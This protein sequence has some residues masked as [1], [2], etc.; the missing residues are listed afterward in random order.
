MAKLHQAGLVE[1]APEKPESYQ[2]ERPPIAA[3][4]GWD[5]ARETDFRSAAHAMGLTQ[6]QV[7]GLVNWQAEDLTRAVQAKQAEVETAT[8]VLL[9]EW[10]A[11]FD[12]KLGRAEQVVEAFFPKSKALLKKTGVNNMP[13]FIRELVAVGSRFA[14]HGDLPGTVEGQPS[15]QQIDAAIAANREQAAKSLNAAE[16]VRLADELHALYQQKLGDTN[17]VHTK[18]G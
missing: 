14:E 8:G 13:E 2:I 3:E 11:N 12:A 5:D 17:V 9:D 10:G 18:I 16:R 7:Q 15:A 6:A 4:F 1:A